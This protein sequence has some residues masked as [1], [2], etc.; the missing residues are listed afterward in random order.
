MQKAVR[1]SAAECSATVA[2]YR[3]GSK[4]A[5]NY[6][7]GQVMKKTRG[8]ADAAEVHWLVKAEVEKGLAFGFFPG[9]RIFPSFFISRP[10][11]WMHHPGFSSSLSRKLLS[12]RSW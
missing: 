11:R 7:V 1:E 3:A 9:R 2:N 5:L 4:R 6:I 10:P 8:K 12:H